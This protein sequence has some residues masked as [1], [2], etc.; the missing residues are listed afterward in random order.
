MNNNMK[1]LLLPCYIY[2]PK[3]GYLVKDTSGYSL[4]LHEI[5]AYLG[6]KTELYVLCDA[7]LPAKTVGN[8]HYITHTKWNILHAL[9][10]SGVWRAIKTFCT[11]KLSLRM[12]FIYACYMA[13]LDYVRKVIMEY[14]PDLV[15]IHAISIRILEE[16][17]ICRALNIPVVVTLH[18]LIGLDVSV[19][20]NCY[21]V[22]LEKELL[23]KT[24][25]YNIPVSL[26]S[27]GVK[28]RAMEFY[29]LSG[30][31]LHVILNGTGQQALPPSNVDVRSLYGI[32]PTQKIILCLGSVCTRK[33]Q[34]ELL[35]AYYYLQMNAVTNITILILGEI[36]DGGALDQA[37]KKR[38]LSEH[39]ILCGFVDKAQIPSYFAVAD[40]NVLPSK[41]EGFG[42]SLIESMVY[43]V[44]SV[45]YADLDA[46]P[47]IYD[48][49]VMLILS[50]RGAKSLALG[51]QQA[52]A[53]NW[54]TEIIRSYG[55]HFSYEAM[56]D[57]YLTLY[58]RTIG[59]M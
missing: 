23:H 28:K 48:P 50:H 45:T 27:T 1:V 51:I 32:A 17:E 56:R 39:F 19:D 6:D 3:D 37:V 14:R 26:I 21:L 9:T 42:L 24:Q 36:R 22:E 53:K 52:L 13:D 20:A 11:T 2:E 16:I 10:L 59:K 57:S 55:Q 35:D 34:M 30:H 46:V 18:G 15:H 40:L 54:D 44:P 4:L 7:L 5:A 29:S 41:D 25:K 8:I 43:G 38:G 49:Q 47:D 31:N 12:R 33:N 58:A